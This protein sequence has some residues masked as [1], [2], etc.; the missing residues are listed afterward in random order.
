MLTNIL[1]NRSLKDLTQYPI[2]PWI[3]TNYN[4]TPLNPNNNEKLTKE[5]LINNHQRNFSIP[6]GLMEINQASRSRK[7]NL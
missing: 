1:C 3:I 5:K 2:F 7:Q 4:I 6:M